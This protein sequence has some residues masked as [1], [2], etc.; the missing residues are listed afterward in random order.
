MA[1]L[2]AV[3][4]LGG[5]F[6]FLGGLFGVGGGIVAIPVLGVGFGM[7]EQAAQGTAL[8]MVVPNVLVGLW[9]YYRL[10]GMD[11]R[12][13]ISLAAGAVPL[14]FIGAHYATHLPSGPLRI[15]FVVFILAIAA[16]MAWRTFGGA[17][18]APHARPWPWPYAIVVGM[19]GGALSGLFSVGGATFAV[20]A[21]TLGFGL[22]QVAA[23]GMAL[24]LVAP[25][26]VVGVVIYALAKDI[27]WPVGIALALGGVFGVSY[28]VGLAH[29]LPDRTLRG[30]FIAFL[31]ASAVAL[32][33]KV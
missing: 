8:V 4:I 20:P 32:G 11:P 3:V 28:G 18:M 14:T 19:I 25:G 12:L 15:A 31:L 22:S 21:M 26:T 13:A 9:R 10:G 2:A 33:L 24:A 29:R 17:R 6:G 16:Y 23:Q 7:S 30:L 1:Y 27:D 5:V